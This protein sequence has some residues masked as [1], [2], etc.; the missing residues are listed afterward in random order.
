MDLHLPILDGWEA[1]R[2][3][4]ANP[5]TKPSGDCFNGNAIGENVKKSSSGGLR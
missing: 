3:I 1:T 2:Q 4:K 5:K